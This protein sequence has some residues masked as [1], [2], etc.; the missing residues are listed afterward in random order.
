MTIIEQ[1]EKMADGEGHLPKVAV[2][3]DFLRAVACEMRRL[4]V[5]SE[6]FNLINWISQPSRQNPLAAAAAVHLSRADK[7]TEKSLVNP[8]DGSEPIA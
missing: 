2:T 7:K 8:V 3:R 6:A 4:T 1:L 5:E